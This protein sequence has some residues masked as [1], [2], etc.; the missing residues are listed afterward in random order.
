MKI[1]AHPQPP[2]AAAVRAATAH[3]HGRRGHLLTA[4]QE[5]THNVGRCPL[6]L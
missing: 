5:Q 3:R 6:C 1:I 4:T 2:S